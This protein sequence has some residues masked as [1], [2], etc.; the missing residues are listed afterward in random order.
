MWRGWPFWIERLW[1]KIDARKAT[2]VVGHKQWSTKM[3]ELEYVDREVGASRTF[4]LLL[5]RDLT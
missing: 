1:W 5:H 4:A 3:S 2:K